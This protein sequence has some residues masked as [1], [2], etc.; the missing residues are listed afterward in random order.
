MKPDASQK[1]FCPLPWTHRHIDTLG[2]IK[3][4]CMSEESNQIKSERHISHFS[5]EETVA[6]SV[7]IRELQTDF[8]EGRVPLACRGCIR[9]EN[10]GIESARVR[11][12]KECGRQSIPETRPIGINTLDLR[13]G[14]H[15][16]LKCVMC[17]PFASRAWLTDW[18]QVSSET[19]TF[20]EEQ[21]LKDLNWYKAPKFWNYLE[22]LLPKIEHLHFAGGEPFLSSE[23]IRT[24]DL[25]IR[26][27]VS[28]R[29]SLSFSTNL[30]TLP[31]NFKKLWGHFKHVRLRV[32]L[33]GVGLV[34]HFIRYPSRWEIIDRHLKLL[35]RASG[36][37]N[38]SEIEIWST[39]QLYNVFHLRELY[40][41]LKQ[42]QFVNH[43]P[44]LAPLTWPQ[45]FSIQQLNLEQ[46]RQI[47]RDI[48]SLCAKYLETPQEGLKNPIQLLLFMN[49]DSQKKFLTKEFLKVTR[50]IESLHKTRCLDVNPQ[51]KPQLQRSVWDAFF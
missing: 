30:T 37:W 18:E 50:K 25:C 49:G 38:I 1:F 23:V 9:M 41:Y 47:E 45:F 27:G 20:E 46:K 34:N 5:S 7:Y 12:L 6:S 15:C 28:H 19:L 3:A 14:N 40:E 24:L 39:V 35:D 51:L 21:N 22:T 48:S 33:D 17:S 2:N 29:M 8:E 36:D 32:S 13:F 10:L 31:E 26:L 11:A 42:F 4:C 16:N 44:F 43:Y